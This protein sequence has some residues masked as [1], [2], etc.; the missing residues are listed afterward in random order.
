[1]VDPG[2]PTSKTKFCKEHYFISN[3]CINNTKATNKKTYYTAIDPFTRTIYIYLFTFGSADEAHML[4]HLYES[5]LDV[6]G[7]VEHF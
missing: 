4:K 2:K 3:E 5:K 1:M 7:V 6:K